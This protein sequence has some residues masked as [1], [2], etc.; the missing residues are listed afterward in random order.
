MSTIL[1]NSSKTEHKQPVWTIRVYVQVQ[2]VSRERT[3]GEKG[4][5]DKSTKDQGTNPTP[6]CPEKEPPVNTG[7]LPAF[8]HAY[9]D[10]T[11]S[12]RKR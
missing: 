4:S 5:R 11:T 3:Y 6:K 1:E 7:H 8:T 2:K 10:L 12:L 9:P